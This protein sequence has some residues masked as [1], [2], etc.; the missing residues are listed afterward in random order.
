[1]IVMLDSSEAHFETAEEE[2][3]CGIGQLLTPLTRYSDRG[4]VYGIDNGC[5]SGFEPRAFM[6]LL[7]RQESARDRCRFVCAPDV[8]GS[9]RRTLEV[10]DTWGPKLHGWP[11][12]LVVQDGAED[13]PMPWDMI[14]AVFVG[15]STKFKV[16][17]SAK[18]VVD[19]ARILGKWT[20]MGR[21]NTPDR[22]DLA[23]SWGID[24]IDGT[25]I[26]RY[27]HM[28]RAINGTGLFD[29]ALRGEGK[30]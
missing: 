25:G 29:T 30:P 16:S 6:S 23:E 14:A 12:A 22:F 4:L 28:R 3:G 17:A 10:F 20:H 5:F 19:A 21:V 15:G 1:M 2:L 9:A 24:S 27:S 8:V 18:S 7:A 26:S 11:V 13:L